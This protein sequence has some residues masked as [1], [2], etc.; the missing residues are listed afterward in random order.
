MAQNLGMAPWWRHLFS[1]AQP[2]QHNLLPK[3]SVFLAEAWR[4][5]LFDAADYGSTAMKP[6]SSRTFR[7][8][9]GPSRTLAIKISTMS[10]AKLNLIYR[11]WSLMTTFSIYYGHLTTKEYM[12][13]RELTHS[14]IRP[15][16]M[17]IA[18]SLEYYTRIFKYSPKMHWDPNLHT[19]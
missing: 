7:A 2:I 17:A 4:P 16:S 19:I 6:L 13:M 9:L 14:P 10:S 1:K 11:A 8:S 3:V 15:P 12:T 5:S 18:R